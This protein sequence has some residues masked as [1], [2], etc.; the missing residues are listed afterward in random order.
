MATA[1]SVTSDVVEINAPGAVLC[2]RL[3]RTPNPQL[4][5]CIN[6]ATGV[7]S[8]FYL[9]FAQWL[10]AEKN[11]AVLIWDYRDFGQSGSPYTSSATMTDWAIT[12]PTATR[13]WM[14]ARYPDA[15]LWV[16]GHSLGGMGTAFQPGT[17]SIDRIITV[18]AGHGH[19][20]DHPWPYQAFV[21]LLW[22]LWGPLGTLMLGYF[23]GRRLRLGNDLPK[24]VFWQWRSWLLDRGALPADQRLGGIQQP[25]YSGTMTL[26]ALDDDHMIPPP[27]VWKM[28]AWHPN[29]Q[30]QQRLLKPADFGLPAIG[31]IRAFSTR[32]RAVWPSLIAP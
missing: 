6:G 30:V 32:N 20:S 5:I 8:S 4:A 14:Q 18:A 29:A 7:P 3:T 21:W 23:P 19:I 28:A 12:D 17:Q 16:I 1:E 25:G 9:P 10:A 13:A 2:G 24:A 11:A 26:V 22:Y 31:H 27:A 15:P